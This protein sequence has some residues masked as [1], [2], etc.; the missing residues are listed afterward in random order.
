MTIRDY[1]KRRLIVG[2]GVLA[3]GVAYFL[4]IA[5]FLAAEDGAGELLVAPGVALAIGGIL[6]LNFALRCPRCKGNLAISPAAYPLS[7][8]KQHRFNFC[9]YCG[10]SA[11]QR[12]EGSK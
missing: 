2:Y 12:I 7:M 3:L 6:Y 5:R 11:D 4:V 8:S 1:V 10:V 9:P